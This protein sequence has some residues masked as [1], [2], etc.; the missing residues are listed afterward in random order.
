MKQQDNTIMMSVFIQ[1]QVIALQHK[2][3]KDCQYV[4]TCITPVGCMIKPHS[5]HG[6]QLLVTRLLVDNVT[7]IACIPLQIW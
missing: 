3:N 6:W 5:L 1:L 7:V 4:H 2:L